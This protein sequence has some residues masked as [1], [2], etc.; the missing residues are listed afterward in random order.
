MQKVW[1]CITQHRQDPS[2]EMG[3]SSLAPLHCGAPQ[4]LLSPPWLRIALWSSC[5]DGP[6]TLRTRD[7]RQP[8]KQCSNFRSEHFL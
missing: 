5:W 2:S 7:I 6:L 8:N 4:H 1:N 3:L